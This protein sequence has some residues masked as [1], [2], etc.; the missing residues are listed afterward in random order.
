MIFLK[1]TLLILLMLVSCYVMADVR[2]TGIGRAT[3]T[4]ATSKEQALADALRDAVRKGVGIN[5]TSRSQASNYILDYDQIF[6]R[7][8]GYI[9]SYKIQ[10]TYTD[11]AGLLTIEIDAVVGKGTPDMNDYLGMQ[12]IINMKGAPRLLIRCHGT[13]KGVGD[14]NKLIAGMLREIALKCGF[15]TIKLSQ[16]NEAE[17]SRLQRDKFTGDKRSADYRNA[18]IR[19][20]Y[21]FVIDANISGNYNGSSKLYGIKTQRFS[22]GADLGATWPNGRTIAQVTLP[23]METDI[24]TVSDPRQAARKALMRY[25]G[26]ETGR[27]FRALL[28]SILSSWVAEFDAGTKI[29]IEFKQISRD[30]FDNLVTA[31]RG[32]EGINAV[33]VREFDE[34]FSSTIEI[35]SRLQSATLARLLTKLSAGKL[36]P[37]NYTVDYIQMISSNVSIPWAI[38]IAGIVGL[39]IILLIILAVKKNQ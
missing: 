8:F 3:G 6:S 9:K 18:A 35:D 15:N 38:I 20:N 34:Q 26:K 13:I 36:K 4:G 30:L 21:D 22:L 33:N 27:N 24:G 2:V 19:Q 32:S 29:T 37:N 10:K 14:S 28:M 25:L 39:L 23:S 1:K 16:F 31:L 12:Q 5:L 7:A 11:N 17:N